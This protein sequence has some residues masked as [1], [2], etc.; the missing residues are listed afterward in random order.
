LKNALRCYGEKRQDKAIRDLEKVKLINYKANAIIDDKAMEYID[1][2]ANP[3]IRSVVEKIK[4]L[5]GT[6]APVDVIIQLELGSKVVTAIGRSTDIIHASV[7]AYI[8]CLN[9]LI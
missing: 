3:R 4:V 2:I 7:E 9:K 6:D 8:E 5:T 1:E